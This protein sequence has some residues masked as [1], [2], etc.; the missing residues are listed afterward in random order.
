MRRDPG[1]KYK[2]Y[3]Q[4]N[5]QKPV[6]RKFPGP[7]PEMAEQQIYHDCKGKK[8]ENNSQFRSSVHFFKNSAN[9]RLCQAETRYL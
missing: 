9:E 7:V 3:G 2:R 1:E 6:K 8:A 4:M 5:A